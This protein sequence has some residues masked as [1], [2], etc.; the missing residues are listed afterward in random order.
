MPRRERCI[1]STSPTNAAS[2]RAT[3]RAARARSSA[4]AGSDARLSAPDGEPA[5]PEAYK[6]LN[7]LGKLPLLVLDDGY[8]IPES[9]IILEWADT[10]IQG[11]TRLIPADA[12]LARRTRFHDRLA[13][14][15]LNNPL[16]TVFFD[17]RK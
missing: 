4:H 9:S 3:M 8:R 7:P 12:D 11:G 10:H 1:A 5:A 6:K 17:S 15:Y 16:L 14:L 2:S 13:D